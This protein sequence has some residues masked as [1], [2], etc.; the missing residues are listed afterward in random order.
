MMTGMDTLQMTNNSSARIR[1]LCLALFVVVST[2]CAAT[3][4]QKPSQEESNPFEFRRSLSW[5]SYDFQVNADRD[6]L[7]IKAGDQTLTD[8]I[9]G[10]VTGAEVGD[11]NLDGYPEVLVFMT[12]VGSGSYGSVIGYS[13]NGGKSMSRINSTLATENSKYTRGYMGHDK[14][15]LVEGTLVQ[16]FPVYR[17]GDLNYKPTGPTRQIQYKLVDGEA[18]R[19]LVVQKMFEY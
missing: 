1:S 14:L 7:T 2:G 16:A 9:D 13:S 8:T 15:S 19:Q 5:Q 17:E 6:K 3:S 10:V 11:L 12:S 4:E 18:A